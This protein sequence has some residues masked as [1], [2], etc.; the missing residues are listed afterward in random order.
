MA[1]NIIRAY[2]TPTP[3]NFGKESCK[4][5]FKIHEFFLIEISSDEFDLIS[6]EKSDIEKYIL[7]EGSSI[8]KIGKMKTPQIVAYLK[9]QKE[10][11]YTAIEGTYKSIPEADLAND[12]MYYAGFR[13][14]YSMFFDDLLGL[15]SPQRLIRCNIDMDELHTTMSSIKKH[16]ID[17]EQKRRCTVITNSTYLKEQ[18]QLNKLQEVYNPKLVPSGTNKSV[19]ASISVNENISGKAKAD[20]EEIASIL[21]QESACTALKSGYKEY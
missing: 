1:L 14:V 2:K 8:E 5:P 4:N 9:E 11:G 12:S 19:S 20:F 21:S 18:E 10:N 3:N 16:I 7:V 6:R 17:A 15:I 13:T